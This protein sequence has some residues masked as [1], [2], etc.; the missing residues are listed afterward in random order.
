MNKQ[1]LIH[2]D[3]TLDKHR[4]FAVI[5]M[6]IFHGVYDLNNFHL[7]SVDF[8]EGFWYWFSRFIAFNFLFCVGVSLQ[9]AYKNGIHFKK[10]WK[11]F[12]KIALGA[13][14][15]SI[16]TYLLFPSHWVYFGTLHCIA[17]SSLL[18]LMFVNRPQISLVMSLGIVAFMLVSGINTSS[19]TQW[20]GRP[21]MDFIPIYP[22]F[23]AV[24]LGLFYEG[25]KLQFL[26]HIFKFTPSFL[27]LLG[28][29][30]LTIYLLHQPLLFGLSMALS[31]VLS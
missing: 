12:T 18:G 2:R 16:T 25:Q 30:A 1:G 26:S 8:S 21:S 15:I 4:G 24:L 29:R 3:Q 10:F 23:F 6:I 20:I 9:K 17:L 31:K 14:V 5:I 22:W 19:L 13:L 27:A 7:V 28:K 11:R